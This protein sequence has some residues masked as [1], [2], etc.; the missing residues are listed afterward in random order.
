[1]ERNVICDDGLGNRMVKNMDGDEEIISFRYG[2]D[3][4]DPTY[5]IN[6]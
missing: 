6:L 1:M 4:L 5:K 3:N 2:S